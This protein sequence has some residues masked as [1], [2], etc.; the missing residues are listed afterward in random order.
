MRT[1]IIGAHGQLGS[2]LARR[3][4][5]AI[6]LGRAEIDIADAASV[7]AAL[8][9]RHPELVI[10]AA[11]YNLVDGAED[12][13]DVAMAVNAGGPRNLARWCAAHDATLVHVSTDYVFGDDPQRD[14]PYTED[15]APGPVSAYGRSK[16]AGE[17][18]VRTECPRHFV[19]RTCG[20]Y[21]RSPTQQKGNFVSTMLR[22]GRERHE[23]RIV[24]D[25]RCTP[26]S[27]TDLADALIS[28]S[29]TNAYGLYHATNSGSATW[30]EFAEEIFRLAGLSVRVVPISSADYG[31]RAQRPPYSV[32][33]CSKLAATLGRPLP[34][35]K[36]ALANFLK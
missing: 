10:N 31:A 9:A 24:D 20:L 7:T 32:L 14:R 12:E 21:G 35:W 5:D 17:N 4:A 27:V 11:A 13:P 18:H 36:A 26:T 2:E 25:Q 8:D 30:R 1:A 23:L 6:P 34:H 33:D 15:D 16:L 3:L 28:L 19:L 29:Q 22:L